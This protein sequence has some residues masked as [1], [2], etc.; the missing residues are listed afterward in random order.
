MYALIKGLLNFT[1]V[2]KT[3]SDPTRSEERI[4]NLAT[5]LAQRFLDSAF[6]TWIAT[7]GAIPNVL[8][9]LQGSSPKVRGTLFEKYADN[10][11]NVAGGGGEYT[12]VPGFGWTN[13]VLLWAG[14]IFSHEL[15][16]PHCGNL[17]IARATSDL[18]RRW[19]LNDHERDAFIRKWRK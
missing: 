12:V 15:R 1:P 7:E 10:N 6:C 4:Y 14:D 17:Q 19:T 18:K 2:N 5:E 13:G 11:I 8:P 3:T 16:Q 9:P